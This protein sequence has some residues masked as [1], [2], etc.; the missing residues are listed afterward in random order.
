MKTFLAVYCLISIIFV[1]SSFESSQEDSS[2]LESVELEPKKRF[3]SSV[4]VK[5][6]RVLD[7]INRLIEVLMRKYSNVK[8]EAINEELNDILLTLKASYKPQLNDKASNH[9]WYLRKG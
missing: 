5:H 9:L 1:V 6:N 8:D 3:I 2:E 7:K 4:H